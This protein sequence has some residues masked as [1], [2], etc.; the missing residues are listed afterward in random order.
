MAKITK[1]ITSSLL[2]AVLFGVCAVPAE[3]DMLSDI[4]A[5]GQIVIAMEGTWAPWTYHDE[6]DALV[7]FD[8]EVAKGIAARLGVKPVFAEGEWDGLFAGMDAGRYDIVV[9]GVEYTEERGQKYDFSVPY[10]YIHTSLVV[11]KNNDAIRSFEDLKGKTTANS[12]ASTYMTLAEQYGAKT[13]GVDTLDETMMMV[14]S[15]R[16]DATLNA[17]VSFYDY[18]KV[19]PE[20][21][22]KEAAQ[23]KEASLVCIPFRKGA[24]SAAFKAAV[25]AAIE[26]LRSS[27]EL[28]AISEKYFGTDITAKAE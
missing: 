22:L 8:V 12:I 24:E 11:L 25:D 3:A 17:N 9:N 16:A 13:L 15:R 20:A 10:G 2:A 7:G 1:K 26:D 14:L 4:Q 28:K 27:G 23:T 5:K 6:K 19:H 21:P 18:M